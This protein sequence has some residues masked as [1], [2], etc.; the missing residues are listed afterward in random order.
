LI[1][2]IG[3]ISLYDPPTVDAKHFIVELREL[4]V[5]I[6]MLTGDV[7]QCRVRLAKS[8]GCPIRRWTI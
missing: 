3:L 4:G 6:K 2:L 8:L 1:G 7:Y 5:K